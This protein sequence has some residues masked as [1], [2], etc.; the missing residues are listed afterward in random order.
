[1]SSKQPWITH[2]H[3]WKSESA[4]M[5]F[6]RGGIRKALW[7]RYPI[8]LELMRQK[9][10]RI[11]N[12]NPKGK[13]KEVWGGECYLCGNDFVQKELQVDH[14]KGNHSLKT[15]DDVQSFIEGMLYIDSD[16]IALVCKSCHKAKSHAERKGISYKEALLEKQAIGMEK[17]LTTK[18]IKELLTKHNYP[19][20]N[21]KDRRKGLIEII[22]GGT[23]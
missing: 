13:L 12:P 18:Q 16:D 14:I 23:K 10:K 3:I 19:C 21:P 15:I 5:S 20:D 1:M 22:R 6:L 2:P 9:R 4:F 11:T 7:N 17:E 8:K